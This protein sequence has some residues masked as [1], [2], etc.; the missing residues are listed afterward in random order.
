MALPPVGSEA[1]DFTLPSTSGEAVTLSSL[2]GRNVLLAFFP[3]AFTRVCTS[4]MCE[5][6]EDYA[7]YQT[8]GTVVVPIS[9]DGIPSLREFRAKE[10]IGPELLSDFHREVSRR[11]GV[12]NEEKFLS[13][14]AYVLI[15]AA[16]VVRWGHVE[17]QAGQRRAT[18]EL[19]AQ[20]HRIG[21][22]H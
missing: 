13:M 7:Q 2:R 15:D 8:A 22:G 1:P 9:V 18:A 19:L 11:Y 20:L 16:G 17:E 21:A 12:L 6:T 5:F 14:R 4:E 3:A 10:K